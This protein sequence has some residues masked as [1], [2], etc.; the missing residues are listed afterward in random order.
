MTPPGQEA[1]GSPGRSIEIR[2]L[3][4]ITVQRAGQ[5]VPIGD[6]KLR[7]LL[8]MLVA[9]EG[10]LLSTAQL[11]SQIWGDDPPRTAPDLIY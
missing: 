2:V 5:P 11:I 6:A 7:M 4:A 1:S 10:R 3:R 9:A 8:A